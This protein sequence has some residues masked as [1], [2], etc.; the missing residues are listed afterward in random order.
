LAGAITLE[1]GASF[2]TGFPT[3]RRVNTTLS[4]YAGLTGF[5]ALAAAN[6]TN[7]S[8]CQEIG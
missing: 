6:S 7:R 1:A 8:G 2:L 3:K 5:F 4:A